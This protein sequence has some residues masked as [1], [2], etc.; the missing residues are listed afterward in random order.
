MSGVSYPDEKK[1]GHNFVKNAQEQAILK[2]AADEDEFNK[3]GVELGFD[4]QYV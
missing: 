3:K 2:V 4:H 1:T